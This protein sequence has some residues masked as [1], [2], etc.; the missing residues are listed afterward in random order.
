MMS[1]NCDAGEI[2]PRQTRRARRERGLKTRYTFRSKTKRYLQH[3][4]G[5]RWACF[6][7][8]RRARRARRG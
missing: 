1:E 8:D 4:T 5:L 2:E 7:I 6:Y 3:D